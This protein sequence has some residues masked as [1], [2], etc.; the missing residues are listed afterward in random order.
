MGDGRWRWEMEMEMGDG[1]WEM[2]DGRWEMGDG[3]RKSEVRS[4]KLGYKI[5]SWG[6]GLGV[7]TE[8]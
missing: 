5:G 6:D 4:Q 3:S 1:R 2:G 8:Y 7:Y